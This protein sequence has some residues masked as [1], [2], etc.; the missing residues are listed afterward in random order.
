MLEFLQQNCP[1]FKEMDED[2]VTQVMD[3]LSAVAFAPNE[4]I[5]KQGKE[6]DKVAIVLEGEA[7]LN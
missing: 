5:L 2:L 6:D 3:K 7:M 4:T 1:E